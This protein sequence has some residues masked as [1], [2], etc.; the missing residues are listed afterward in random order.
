MG[1][2]VAIASELLITFIQA[3]MLYQKQQGRSEEEISD[4]FV[5]TF[6]KFMVASAVPVDPVKK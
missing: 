4:A 2:E 5:K 6:G 3:W 1:S